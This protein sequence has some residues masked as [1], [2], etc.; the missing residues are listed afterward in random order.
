MW[1]MTLNYTTGCEAD[2]SSTVILGLFYTKDEADNWLEKNSQ[3]INWNNFYE[4]TI[5][6]EEMEI[7]GMVFDPTKGK[8]F[9]DIWH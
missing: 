1:I 2:A 6:I 4:G 3:Y 5:D 7:G 9:F 8:R